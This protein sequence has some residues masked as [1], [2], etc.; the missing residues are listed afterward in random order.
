MPM[1]A[2]IAAYLAA[3][4]GGIGWMLVAGA[5]SMFAG[6]NAVAA[7]LALAIAAVLWRRPSRRTELVALVLAPAAIAASIAFG[8][9]VDGVHRWLAIGPLRLHAA[10][11]FGPAF[12]VAFQRRTDWLGSAAAIVMAGLVA[13]Q[14]D[15]GVALALA[16]AI[17]LALVFEFRWDR[18][19][20]FS[21]SAAALGFTA[22]RPD[23]LDPVPFV[24]NVLQDIW[25]NGSLPGLAI[26]LAL[27]AAI[28]A[29][30]LRSTGRRTEGAA[31]AGWFL[32]LAA[33]SLFRPFPTPLIGYGAAPILGYGIA[34]GLLG[35]GRAMAETA[36]PVHI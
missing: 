5:P 24:E 32:G 6:V 30:V 9:D 16:C 20:A 10:A 36:K 11:L 8:P 17:G 23:R 15:M 34:L 25:G 7:L 19:I 27:L 26:P 33:A 13:L 2:V 21:A 18:M 35:S 28:A 4:A 12:L 14:P 22:I 31:V 1:R 3:V 29:P